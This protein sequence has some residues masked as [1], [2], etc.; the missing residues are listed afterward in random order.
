MNGKVVFKHAVSRMQEA[1]GEALRENGVTIGDVDLLVPHQANL[2]II[3]NVREALGVPREKVAVNIPST[4]T[5]PAPRSRSRSTR[6]GAKD[7]SK[8]AG[9]CAGRVRLGLYLGLGPLAN[10]AALC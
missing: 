8:R 6:A 10:L 1:V 4:A 9:W 5:P 7:G 2:R 3:E